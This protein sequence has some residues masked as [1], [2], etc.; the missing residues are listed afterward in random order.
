M[1]DDIALLTHLFSSAET[2][3]DSLG[4]IVEDVNHALSRFDQGGL[5]VA[6]VQISADILA[7]DASEALS[8]IEGSQRAG[9]KKEQVEMVEAAVNA[10]RTALEQYA[11]R[12]NA[13]RGR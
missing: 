8:L 2:L 12:S 7:R 13:I 10:L 6:S 1:H 3:K 9:S 11:E 5:N 4:E